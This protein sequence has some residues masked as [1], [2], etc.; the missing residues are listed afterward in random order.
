MEIALWHVGIDLDIGWGFLG[1]KASERAL[2]RALEKAEEMFWPTNALITVECV[3]EKV[4]ETV[5]A[6]KQ[7]GLCL[8]YF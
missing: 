6:E 3:V 5:S 4:R 2:G 8:D 7:L 1:E